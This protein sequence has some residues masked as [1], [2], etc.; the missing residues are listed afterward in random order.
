MYSISSQLFGGITDA[1]FMASKKS[2]SENGEQ[3]GEA[4]S[5]RNMGVSLTNEN[6][7]TE[8][9][10]RHDYA[11]SLFEE[12]LIKNGLLY[13]I[14]KSSTIETLSSK[15]FIKAKGK[16]FFD[17]YEVLDNTMKNFNRTG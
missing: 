7:T 9:K 13:T 5:G 16:V 17:D 4:T 11:Y 8:K 15:T 1:I 6:D 10:F 2:Y 3:K 14:D 12:E